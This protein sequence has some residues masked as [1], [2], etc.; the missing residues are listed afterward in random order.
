MNDTTTFG[1][2]VL[3]ATVVGL[4][5][6]MSPSIF[7]FSRHKTNRFPILALNIVLGWTILGW[8]GALLW[9]CYDKTDSTNR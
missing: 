8:A 1:L 5:L 3:A 2:I 7:A 4:P 9:A 6:Y